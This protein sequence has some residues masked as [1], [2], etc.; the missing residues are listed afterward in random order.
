MAGVPIKPVELATFANCLGS[1]KCFAVPLTTAA[2]TLAELM[3]A[4][5]TLSA[6]LEAVIAVFAF[7]ATLATLPASLAN[8]VALP[9]SSVTNNQRHNMFHNV[10][11]CHSVNV[12]HNLLWQ[13]S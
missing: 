11:R 6:I 3:T 4:F 1:T 2:V 5:L 13:S 12:A 7:E 9:A 10:Y 8:F